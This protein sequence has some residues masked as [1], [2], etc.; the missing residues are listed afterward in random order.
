MSQS[1]NNVIGQQQNYPD[2]DSLDSVD[3]PE[4]SGQNGEGN[5][6]ALRNMVGLRDEHV[7][8]IDDENNPTTNDKNYIQP[9]PFTILNFLGIVLSIVLF[10]FDV[11]TDILL[12]LKYK[13]HGRIVE[14]VLTSSVVIA[15][16][17]VTG[18]L[19]TIWYLQDGSG[20]S[21][22][23]RKFLF[24]VVAFPFSTIIRNIS[25]LKHGCLSR[26]SS[27]KKAKEKHYNEMKKT[28]LDASFL[29]MFDAFFESAPQLIIQVYIAIHDTHQQAIHL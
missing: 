10:V 3:A 22:K 20:P 7:T 21:G 14:C 23:V 11:V 25:H 2:M 24:L 1:D 18:S 4:K 19:S 26:R 16:F 17:M 15:S 27:D 5:R 13:N 28:G 12:A 8:L 29:R 9:Y 6:I